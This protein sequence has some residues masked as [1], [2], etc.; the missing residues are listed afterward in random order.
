MNINNYEVIILDC[1]GVVFD[2]NSLKIEAFRNILS[3]YDNNTVQKFTKYF[4]QNFGTSRYSLVKIFITDFLKI[5]FNEKL[6]QEIIKNYGLQCLRL[7]KNANFTKSLIDFLKSYKNKKLY[8]ASGSDENELKIVLE[9]RG[10]IHFFEK[11]YGSPK[12][13]TDLIK[14]I[15]AQNINKNILMIG[16]AQSDLLASKDN[17]ID[18]IFMMDYSTNI[19]MK[20]NKSLLS[21]KN[22]GDLI[23]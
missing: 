15:C 10:I 9:K 8:I 1:D 13:K 12:K 2:S 22:L 3:K 5:K 20:T 19:N 23:N 4:E 16:D 7:Y 18:F 11:I 21:I 6:Y 14:N 17:S